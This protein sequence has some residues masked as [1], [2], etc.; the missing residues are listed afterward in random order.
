MQSATPDRIS[1]DSFVPLYEQVKAYVRRYIATGNLPAG[2]L[3]PSEQE[4]CNQ[5]GV[6]RTTVIK[7]L[8]D[9]AIEGLVE[10]IQG[11]GTLVAA[12][13]VHLSLKT[14]MGFGEAMERQGLESHSTL[15]QHRIVSGDSRIRA[16]FSLRPDGGEEFIE[17]LRLRTV[18]HR[19]AVLLR[20]TVMRELGEEI[21]KHELEDAS[22]YSLYEKITG[23][24]VS[25]SEDVLSMTEVHSPQ[26]ELLQ[27]PVGSTHF[28]MYGAS[29]LEG[30]LPVEA[31]E[32]I[33][34]GS[35]F[36]FQVNM[37]KVLIRPDGERR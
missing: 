33:F 14:V 29:Y 26:A 12:P 7:A 23:W 20:C 4:L 21:L 10:R 11:K 19:P 37:T 30:D 15:L 9:L 3:L 1:R 18:Q 32:G 2:T 34:V 36:R 27:V 13:Q 31:T 24:R 28:F 17:F 16:V 22:F 35:L 8:N 5:L 6:S 25:R